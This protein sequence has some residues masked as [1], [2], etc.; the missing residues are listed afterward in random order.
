MTSLQTLQNKRLLSLD[1]Y[2]GIIMFLLVAE[3]AGLFSNSKDLFPEGT[4]FMSLLE[5]FEHPEWHGLRFWDLL[6]PSF[7][8]IIGVA[9]VFSIESRLK[10]GAIWK[11]IFL[12][13]LRRSAILF[14]LGLTITS[15]RSGI[16]SWKLWNVLVSF[17][18]SILVC[19]LIFHLSLVTQF[20]VSL[21]LVIGYDVCYMLWNVPG[22]DQPYVQ[23]HDL[24]AFIDYFLTGVIPKHGWSAASVIPG[25]ALMI[26]GMVS[27]RMLRSEK[28]QLQ[29]FKILALACACFLSVGYILSFIGIPLNKH[30]FTSS[31]TIVSCGY[32]LLFLSSSYWLVDMKGRK[33]W[34]P[35][36]TC[37]GMNSIFIYVFAQ[38]IARDGLKNILALYTNRFMVWF[39]LPHDVSMVLLSASVIAVEWYI[40]W[41]LYKRKIVIKI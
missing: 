4:I 12:H 25:T 21:A 16:L 5:Q 14:L 39:S 27:A 3:C 15:Y 33:S 41:F 29:K 22:F 30:I 23:N 36:F 38:T 35:F 10:K 34:A 28:S 8:F 19:V 6:H 13:I 37:V 18:V 1:L 26:W 9:M 31:Y 7:T 40:C 2:R 24:G 20:V 32:C 17:S 11:T